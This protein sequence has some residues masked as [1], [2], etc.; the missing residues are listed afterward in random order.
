MKDNIMNEER[1]TG[2]AEVYKM[3]RPSYP[4]NFVDYLYSQVGFNNKSLIADIGSGT[5]VFSHLLLK[6]GST[7]YCVEPNYDMR[8]TAERDLLEFD[9]FISFDGNDVSTGLLE[10]SVDFVT[11]A[12]AFHW[13]NQQLFKAECQRI[14]KPKG[15]V[16]LL[17]NERDYESEIVKKDYAIRQKYAVG[18]KKGLGVLRTGKLRFEKFFVD[19]IY[20]YRTFNNHLVLD[21]ENY[22]GMNLSRSYSPSEDH[23][24]DEYNGFVQELS[25]LFDAYNQNGILNFPHYTQSYIGQA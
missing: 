6:R 14:L 16:V 8:I 2:K 4:N 9:N 3:F 12:Q 22:I 17:W 24:P 7:V 10:R 15:K 13:F 21:R 23:N 20:E 18:D 5:G 1:F 25:N 19:G 11:A